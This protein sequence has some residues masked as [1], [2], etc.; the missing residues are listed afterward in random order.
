MCALCSAE[1]HDPA[2]RR[3]HA[4]PNACPTCGPRLG[5]VP[6]A[7]PVAQPETEGTVPLTQAVA[8]LQAG[9]VVA[10]K[11]IGGFHLACLAADE[12]AVAELRARKHREEKPF[13]LMAARPRR[14]ARSWSSSTA[15]R[16]R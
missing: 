12:D 5:T 1:Y 10:V 9:G 8:V 16:R 15:S 11:G 6:P 14:R 2:D 4:Q 7:A 3:F 13:A